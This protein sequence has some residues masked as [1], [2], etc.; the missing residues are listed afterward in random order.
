M[1]VYDFLLGFRDLLVEEYSREVVMTYWQATVALFFSM[2]CG[3]MV[4]IVVLFRRLGG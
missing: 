1:D 3:G 2:F 4:A